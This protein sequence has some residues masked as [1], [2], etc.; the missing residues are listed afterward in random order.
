MAGGRKHDLFISRAPPRWAAR[1]LSPVAAAVMS[2]SLI[3]EEPLRAAVYAVQPADVVRG[4]AP[5]LVGRPG[6]RQ[7]APACPVTRWRDLHRVAH[8]VDVRLRKSACARSPQCCPVAPS[9]SPASSR[10]SGCPALRRWPAPPYPP[11][12]LAPSSRRVT[13]CRHP[14]PQ[15]PATAAAQQQRHALVP[16]GISRARRRP[17]PQSSGPSSWPIFSTSVTWRPRVSQVLRH[18]QADE[19]AADHRGRCAGDCASTNC[20][21]AQRVLHGAQGETPAPIPRR[22]GRARTGRAPGARDQ[23]VVA[24]LIARCRSPGART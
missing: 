6:Q 8:G 17:C 10:Q 23:L 20:A 15:S 24:F 19:A 11:A 3:T 5:L 1:S 16:T 14:F 7:P 2:N 9:S 4:H 21:D 18:F 22:A 13:R 12:R